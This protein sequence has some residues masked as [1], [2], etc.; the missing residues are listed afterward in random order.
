MLCVEFN[1]TNIYRTILSMMEILLTNIFSTLAIEVLKECMHEK[2]ILQSSLCYV[3]LTECI[4]SF[5]VIG[6]FV[7]KTHTF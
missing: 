5:I 4:F 1:G 3:F 2:L 6:L 7:K